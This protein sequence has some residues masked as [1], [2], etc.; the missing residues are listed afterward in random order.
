MR[1][2]PNAGERRPPMNGD[3]QAAGMQRSALEPGT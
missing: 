2:N 1:V 3:E